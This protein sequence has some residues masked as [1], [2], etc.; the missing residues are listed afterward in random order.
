MDLPAGPWVIEV[1]DGVA[2]ARA[3]F[4][5]EGAKTPP[6]KTPDNSADKRIDDLIAPPAPPDK[7]PC[8]PYLAKI[9]QP[10][11]V[12][13]GTGNLA[14]LP[15]PEPQPSPQTIC[16][17]NRPR[18]AQPGCVEAAVPANNEAGSRIQEKCKPNIPSYAQPGCIP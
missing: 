17:S 3:E 15:S 1:S 9:W 5:I 8:N 2:S 7:K 18:Y 16:D 6:E 14:G 4:R 13:P 11:C 10:G 12:E